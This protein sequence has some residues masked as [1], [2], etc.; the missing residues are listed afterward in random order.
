MIRLL[1]KFYQSKI[2]LFYFKLANF[3]SHYMVSLLVLFIRIWMARI[4]WYSGLSKIS[5]IPAT[6]YLFEYEYKVACIPPEIAAYLSTAIELSMPVFLI[7]GLFSRLASIPLIVM[8]L[9]IR[10]TYPDLVEHAYWLF[11]L[12]TIVFYGSGKL[13]LDYFIYS[14]IHKQN[15][16]TIQTQRAVDI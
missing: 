6:I 12:S 5:D 3:A 8:T 13:S 7:I 14:K 4:F 9:I 2:G 1:E 10:L 11:L 16:R 15:V